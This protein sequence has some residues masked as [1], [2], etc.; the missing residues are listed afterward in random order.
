ML[1]SRLNSATRSGPPSGGSARCD[2]AI[3]GAGPYGLAARSALRATGRDV[4]QFGRPMSFWRQRMPEG[5]LIRSPWV[6]TSFTDRGSGLTL[7]DYERALPQPLP[8]R[9]PLP[10]FIDYGEWFARRTSP[11]VD[12]RT[13][14]SIHR[15]GEG[16]VLEL[17]DGEPVTAQ[18]VVIAAGIERFAVRPPA[19]G[20][21]APELAL[22]TTELRRPGAWSGLRVLVVGGGQSALESAA[23][24]HEAGADVEVLVRAPRVHWLL[25]SQ[26]LHR[27]GAMTQLL[28]APQDIGP[29]GLSRLVPF[30]DVF[31]RMPVSLR[32]RLD[33]RAIRPAGSGWLVPRLSAVAIRTGVE[34]VSATPQEGG[35]TVRLS[36]GE[37]RRADRIVLG[38][39]FRVDLARYEF[40]PAELVARVR[41]IGG[42]P[43]LSAG[44]E[45]SVPGVFFLG[46]VA[47]GQFGPLLRFVAGAGFAAR[48]LVG[49]LAAAG[50]PAGAAGTAVLE[51]A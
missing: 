28:Y 33:T 16:F 9:L 26:R 14:R 51:P 11:D 17:D 49:G 4:R 18:R 27:L 37:R 24:L 35:I 7:D 38:T 40:L 22:H 8:R 21:L 12:E 29:A 46:T 43:V 41:T 34:V 13:V 1:D 32:R 15:R 47:A 50:V 20:G 44:F 42:Y 25:R 36:T 45:S 39:G 48:R 10:R 6:A 19:F 31:A 5:M 3:V 2:I 30:P 23:L